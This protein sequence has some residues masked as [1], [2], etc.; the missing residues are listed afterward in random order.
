[1]YSNIYTYIYI[2]ICYIYSII[3]NNKQKCMYVYIT[4]IL[5]HSNIYIY[6]Y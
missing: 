1:M 5:L 6:I 3:Y 4:N 2:Y